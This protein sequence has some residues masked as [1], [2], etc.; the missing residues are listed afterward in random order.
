[1]DDKLMDGAGLQYLLDHYVDLGLAHEERRE[2]ET[3]LLESPEARKFFWRQ[4]R[5]HALLRHRRRKAKAG[6]EA[7]NCRPA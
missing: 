7:S 4:V 6:S 2:L 5:F 1:M 3:L